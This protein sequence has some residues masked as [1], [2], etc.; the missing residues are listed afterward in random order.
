M[1][2]KEK[3]RNKGADNHGQEIDTFAQARQDSRQDCRTQAV[4][5]TVHRTN[6]HIYA[7]NFLRLRRSRCWL[8]LLTL[9]AE[10]RGKIPNGGNVEAAELVGN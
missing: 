9:E 7:Q 1:I 5:L 10:V 4:R 3:R 6:P 2:I 8:P